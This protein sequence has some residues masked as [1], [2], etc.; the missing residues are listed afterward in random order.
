VTLPSWLDP[1][2]DAAQMRAADTWAIEQQGVPSLELMERAGTGLAELAAE[3]AP[4]GRIAVVVGKGNNGGDGLVAARVLRER[5]HDVDVLLTGDAGELSGD[6][7]ANLA[8]LPGPAPEQFAA[9]RLRGAAGVVDALL[10]TGFSGAPREPLA[11]AIEAVNAAG[12]AVVAADV[13][14]G[15][16]ASTGAVEGAAVR[17][18]A[19]A[20]FH[21]AK[22]G[23]YVAPGKHCAGDVRV[24]EIGIPPGAPAE[25]TAGLIRP[26]VLALVPERQAGST[27]FSEGAVM[28]AGGSLGLTGAPCMAAEA[29]QRAGAG[30]VT[31]CVPQSLDLVFELRLLEAMSHPLADDDGALGPGAVRPVLEA[32]Q[33]ADALAL[34]PGLGRAAATFEFAR[35]V[36]AGAELPLLLDADGLNAHAGRLGDLASRRAPTV[37][38]P[39]AGELGRLLE[40][41]SA[42]V[43][44]AR[45][46]HARAA[47][48]SAKAVVVLKG[49][50]TLVAD[51]D[52]RVGVSPG[53]SPGLATAGTGDVLSGITAAMLAK[54][55]PPFD[56]ACA[57]VHLHAVAGRRAAAAVGAGSVIARDVIEALAPELRDF[58][59]R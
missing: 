13:P 7:A 37:L 9:E 22:L 42:A 35:A 6:P 58:R 1:L 8:R 43:E 44:G 23:L 17:A 33:R 55:L 19:T 32:A 54:G 26:G 5:G 28:V 24:V 56:A 10:G 39:H 25:A 50:D 41:D 40:T 46:H 51:P 52:G 30:Y 59:A 4:D 18:Q 53:G 48:A 27:K 16:D 36:A 15:V 2:P 14:S 45:L 20:T 31:V 47:A 29:A 34:G 21:S 49:D 11:S 57:A 12:A 38:T 3:R